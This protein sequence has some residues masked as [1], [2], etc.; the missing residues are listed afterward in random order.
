[1]S[2]YVFKKQELDRI[3]SE[4]AKYGV[5]LPS[6]NVAN[7]TKQ[8]KKWADENG[9]TGSRSVTHFTSFVDEFTSHIEPIDE[10]SDSDA[11]ELLEMIRKQENEKARILPIQG[12]KKR[13]FNWLED[14]GYFGSRSKAAINNYIN[15]DLNWSN[16]AEIADENRVASEERA[17]RKQQRSEDYAVKNAFNWEG[18]TELY[19]DKPVEWYQNVNMPEPAEY[20][21]PRL[22]E[23]NEPKMRR[24]KERA[25]EDTKN[26]TKA[27][28]KYLRSEL[29]E[30]PF[31][32]RIMI[33]IELLSC[34]TNKRISSD[35]HD[36]W[37]RE[38]EEAND[39]SAL[40][41]EEEEYS[42][43]I[44]PKLR[45]LGLV[46][47]NLSDMDI[48]HMYWRSDFPATEPTMCNPLD[49]NVQ[50]RQQCAT[51]LDNN[52]QDNNVQDNN[53]QPIGQ[54]CATIL[55][56]NVQPPEVFI[57]SFIIGLVWLRH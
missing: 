16:L 50:P 22:Y 14:Q 24:T 10:I 23:T 53:V 9:F 18:L 44:A 56:N 37:I 11:Y 49:N 1:M 32:E 47:P 4:L 2:R 27:I 38:E 46:D 25:I 15:G 43:V 45:E 42:K 28:N 34:K 55:D 20:G 12:S 33:A 29:I 3:Y 40:E 21:A 26:M 39:F 41:Q 17:Q 54:Q 31:R 19:D 5:V 8:F 36:E 30:R 35:Q 52:V 57:G 51:I 48:L 6:G 13:L 7:R